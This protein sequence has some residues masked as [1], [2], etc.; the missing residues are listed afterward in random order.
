MRG[1]LAERFWAKVNKAGPVPPHKPELG[2]CWVWTASTDNGG[3][4]KLGV[5]GKHGGHAKA[6]RVAWLL[7]YGTW[8]VPNALHHC[9]NRLCVRWDHLFEGTNA[10]NNRDAAS[11]GRT[12]SGDRHYSRRRPELVLRGEANGAAK[13]TAAQVADIRA[14]AAAGAHVADMAAAF[15]VSVRLV[16]GILSGEMRRSG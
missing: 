10:D 6:A 4:G 13:L 3:Y 11:K 8:P 1:T 5:G 2:P 15:G 14:Q 16:Y 9:D 12:A 7:Q